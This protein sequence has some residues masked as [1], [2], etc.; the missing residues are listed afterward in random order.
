MAVLQ[1]KW[2]KRGV[3]VAALALIVLG[4]GVGASMYSRYDLA[5]I[6]SAAPAFTAQASD[7]STVD[8]A[9]YRN[10]KRVVLVFYPGDY[11]PVCTAQLCAFRDRWADLKSGDAVVYGINPAQL[12]QH[13]G[14][15]ALNHLPFP[16]LADSDG[17]IASR[18]G[19]RALF[20]IVKRTVYVIDRRGHVVWAER[21]NPSPDQIVQ[22]LKD[23]HDDGGPSGNR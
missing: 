21:G 5:P 16:L 8:L 2:T 11:T 19:C 12:S 1:Q 4:G 23:L 14:F 18:Y 3:G 17:K 6:G 20:G 9:A 22:I 15:A 10:R 13:A 7:G